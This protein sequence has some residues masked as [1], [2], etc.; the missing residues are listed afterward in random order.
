MEHA[1]YGH[2]SVAEGPVIGVPAERW[3]EVVLAVIVPVAGAGWD[4]ADVL[5]WAATRIARYKLPKSIEW[6]DAPPRNLTGKVLRRL[7]RDQRRR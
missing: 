6:V 5:V 1:I 2:P 4:D 3:G 7:L